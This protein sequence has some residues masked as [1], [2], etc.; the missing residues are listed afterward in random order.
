MLEI[1]P[2]P[3]IIVDSI[4]RIANAESDQEGLHEHVSEQLYTQ[5]DS[6][7]DDV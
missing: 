1:V 4:T 2:L 3:S 7:D 5:G 6:R